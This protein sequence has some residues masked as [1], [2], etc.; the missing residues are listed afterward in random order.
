MQ[1]KTV[2]IC[3][4]SR[5]RILPSKLLAAVTAWISPVKCKLNYKEVIDVIYVLNANQESQPRPLE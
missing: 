5:Q 2:N 3:S 1:R 4:A